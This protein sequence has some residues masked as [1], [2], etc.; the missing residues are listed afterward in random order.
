MIV[1]DHPVVREG[2]HT[3]VS[4]QSDMQ[5]VAHASTFDDALLRF[6]E[7]RP[8]VTIM[9][10]MG[11]ERDSVETIAALRRLSSSAKVIIFSASEGDGSILRALNAGA[12]SYMFKSTSREGIVDVIRQ[13]LTKGRY[14]PPE[15]ASK[16]AE[17][18]GKDPLTAREIEVLRL[19]REGQRNKQIA[20]FLAVAETTVNF[21]I[22]NVLEKLR[23]ND[24]THAVT[25]AIRRGLL[26]IV[27]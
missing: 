27:S 21:H 6:R 2:L 13:V 7:F 18:L 11:S 9:D 8:D 3:I 1:E 23:A 19:V 24:R 25:I 22:K 17:H 20:N 16:I 15:I 14:I 12:A 5:V 26:S 10:L 4:S